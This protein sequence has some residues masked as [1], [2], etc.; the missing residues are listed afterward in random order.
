MKI[1]KPASGLFAIEYWRKL[2]NRD[3]SEMVPPFSLAGNS[4]VFLFL[5]SAVL[6]YGMFLMRS[7]TGLNLSDEGFVWYGV[8]RVLRGEIPVRDFYSYDPARYYW[9][10]LWFYLWRPGIIPLRSGD[11]AMQFFGIF[12]GLMAVQPFL[13]RYWQP[14]LLGLVLILWTFQPYKC[15]DSAIPPIA[16]CLAV[17]FFLNPGKISALAYGAFVGFSPFVGRN[18]ALYLFASALFLWAVFY[19]KIKTI[20]FAACFWVAGFIVGLSPSLFMLLF[21]KGYATALVDWIT[22]YQSVGTNIHLPVPWPWSASGGGWSLPHF[23]WAKKILGSLFLFLPMAY[24]VWLLRYWTRPKAR[25][26]MAFFLLLCAAVGLPYLHYAFDRA[27]FGHL[28]FVITPFWLG[29]F[30]QAFCGPK[31]I[32]LHGALFLGMT[33]WAVVLES[34]GYQALNPTLSCPIKYKIG[35]DEMNLNSTTASVIDL[36]G[37]IV[38]TMDCQGTFLAVPALAGI[39]SA[40]NQK[41]PIREIFCVMPETRENQRKIIREMIE[42]KV[43]WIL[44][45]NG[46]VDQREELRFTNAQSDIWDFMKENYKLLLVPLP[47]DYFLMYRSNP[48][49]PALPPWPGENKRGDGLK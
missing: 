17:R 14:V 44:V 6:A 30:V 5:V 32:R 26:P 29:F 33:L 31:P 37:K 7:H 24:S 40:L 49:M 45:Y 41:S 27:D 9:S 42:N 35:M 8:E 19:P 3:I 22:R 12:A 46:T 18:H 38:Q 25:D 39:Y 43:R 20:R 34:N 23:D 15:F 4:T 47:Q 16:L 48:V 2:L 1:S 13:R 10:S 36:S 21:V 28:S 11:A